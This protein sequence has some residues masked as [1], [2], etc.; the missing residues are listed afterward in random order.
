MSILYIRDPLSM[1]TQSNISKSS[2]YEYHQH[3]ETTQDSV[4]HFERFIF[5]LNF[6]RINYCLWFLP[7][8]TEY[9]RQQ[10]LLYSFQLLQNHHPHPKRTNNYTATTP[11]T[12][13]PPPQIKNKHPIKNK[14]I[15]TYKQTNTNRYQYD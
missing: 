8:S 4:K 15:C 13:Q 9:S 11:S 7:S 2:Y 1:S 10:S 5:V 14:L 3:P 12:R 6:L